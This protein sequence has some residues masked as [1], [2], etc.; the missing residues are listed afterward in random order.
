MDPK[1]L[2]WHCCIAN[3]KFR[4]RT[5]LRG[6][7]ATARREV[8]DFALSTFPEPIHFSLGS[9]TLNPGRKTESGVIV[10]SPSE[11]AFRT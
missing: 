3:P 6:P 10:A 4:G 9:V 2:G 11:S 1:Q 5:A 8:P 7:L